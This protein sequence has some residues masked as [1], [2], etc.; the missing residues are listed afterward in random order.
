MRLGRRVEDPVQR[1]RQLHRTEVRAQVSAGTGHRVAPGSP[2]SPWPASELVGVREL[3]RSAGPSTRSS[4]RVT[5]TIVRST[6]LRGIAHWPGAS[7]RCRS[8]RSAITRLGAE[9]RDT[10]DVGG[11]RE[12]VERAQRASAASRPPRRSRR[13]GPARPGRRRRS[14][15]PAGRSASDRLDDLPA[16]AGARRVEHHDVDRDAPIGRVPGIV[17]SAHP[18]RW[19]T[20]TC[21]RSARFAA[22]SAA[23]CGAGLDADHAPAGA[24]RAGERGGERA[25]PGVQVAAPA[26]PAWVAA[27]PAAPAANVSAAAGA[28]ARSRRRRHLEVPAQH[29]RAAAAAGPRDQL[30]PV[31][32]G[33][34]PRAW[35]PGPGPVP[36]HRHLLAGAAHDLD[37]RSAPASARASAAASPTAGGAEQAAVD[38]LDLVR[39]VLAQPGPAGAVDGVHGRG[40]ASPAARRGSSSTSCNSRPTSRCGH[41]RELLADHLRLQRRCAAPARVLPVAAAAA[42]RPGV[43]AG[44]RRPGPARPRGSRPRRR[45]STRRRGPRSPARGPAHRAARAGRTTTAAASRRSRATQEPPCAAA[46]DVAARAIAPEQRARLSHCAIGTSFGRRRGRSAAAAPAG[47]DG[48]SGRSGLRGAPL[49]LDVELPRH[50]R[51]HHARLEQQPGLE[52]QR[53]LVVQQVLPPVADDVLGDEH[54][55]DVARP[56]G[57]QLLDVVHDRAA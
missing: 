20:S 47:A 25:G 30:D 7:D 42:P 56:V 16:G 31:R 44:R 54:A 22:A 50:A 52:P 38:V 29:G 9:H 26:P 40:S 53:R 5:R 39:A 17:R 11:H 13:R 23:A 32:A 6:D 51:D 8:D 14:R 1:D 48:P 2:G 19:R 37:R 49:A 18:G 21:G 57:A 33:A 3:R 45:S 41:P 36:E 10:L 4:T 35:R 43:R 28:P 46:A 12:R 15:R 27:R 55:D 34:G 24:D